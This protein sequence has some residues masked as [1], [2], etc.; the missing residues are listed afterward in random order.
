MKDKLGSSSD[1]G[2]TP[3]ES[4]QP[5][6]LALAELLSEGIRSGQYAVG[7]LLPTEA[8]LCDAYDVSRHTVR[9]AIRKLRDLG[10][11][12]R[13]QGVGTRVE[14]KDISGRFVLSLGSIPDIWQYVQNTRLEPIRKKLI[15][16]A[17]AEIPLPS[18]GNDEQWFLTEGLRYVGDQ[19]L[20]I[21]HSAIHVNAAFRGIG[22]QIGQKQVPIFSMIERRYGLKVVAIKQEI[23]AI[24]MP[25]R[26]TKPLK[27]KPDS[28]ALS[29]IRH[30]TTAEGVIVEV[31]RTITPA[32]RF[33]YSMDLRFEYPTVKR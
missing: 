12:S 11:V 24:I 7:T 1:V 13:H 10:L 32:D 6:Y 29:I 31:G 18:V 22:E 2:F 15:K 14:N 9:E 3:F 4:A 19:D 21:S 28:P 5:R 17:E 16:A 27:V 26:L 25:A 23:S 33:T 20:P 8:E 30:Y